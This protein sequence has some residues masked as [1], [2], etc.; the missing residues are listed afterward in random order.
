VEAGEDLSGPASRKEG[1]I[2]GDMRNLSVDLP[3]PSDLRVAV[4]TGPRMHVMRSV[5]MGGLRAR[6]AQ[7]MADRVGHQNADQAHAAQLTIAHQT[8]RLGGVSR[9]VPRTTDEELQAAFLRYFH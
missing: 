2:R 9:V 8:L 3:A 7:Q 1:Q 4:G 6:T 5:P